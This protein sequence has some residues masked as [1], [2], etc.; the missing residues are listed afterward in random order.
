MRAMPRKF[1]TVPRAAE[2]GRLN[3]TASGSERVGVTCF[4]LFS[5]LTTRS[6]PLAVL[7]LGMRH[8]FGLDVLVELLAG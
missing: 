7:L 5:Q 6:L 4:G 2:G 3:S 1:V 8:L